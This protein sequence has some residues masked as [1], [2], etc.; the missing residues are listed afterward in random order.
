MVAWVQN[1]GVLQEITLSVN[2]SPRTAAVPPETTLLQFLRDFLGLTG[3]KYGCGEGACGACT[4]LVD[5]KALRSCTV[6]AAAVRGRKITTIEG[7]ATDGRLHPVQRAFLEVEAFQCGFC[8]PGM[9]LGAVSLLRESAAPAESDV[10]KRLEAHLCRC[11]TYPR[12]VEAVRLA[13][14]EVRHG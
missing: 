12:I 9:I 13:A 6:R 3:A 4:V 10:R 5:G 7:L 2:G 11:G 8:T 14:K 1:G